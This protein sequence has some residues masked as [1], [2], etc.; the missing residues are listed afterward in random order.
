MNNHSQV[1]SGGTENHKSSS[2]LV[3]ISVF[4]FWGF[5]AA[6]NGKVK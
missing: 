6:S 2:F 5:V 3:L 1:V 4:F